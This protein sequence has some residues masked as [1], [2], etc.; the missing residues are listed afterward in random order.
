MQGKRTVH[1]QATTEGSK[2]TPLSST[3]L[4]Q[5]KILN[6]KEVEILWGL[7]NRE[8]LPEKGV[9][10]FFDKIFF[11]KASLSMQELERGL[12]LLDEVKINNVK[13]AED[14]QNKLLQKIPSVQKESQEAENQ[15]ALLQTRI[16]EQELTIRNMQEEI[17][18]LN[19]VQ[20]ECVA[21]RQEIKQLTATMPQQIQSEVEKTSEPI[22]SEISTL[23][24]EIKDLKIELEQ[25]KTEKEK[26]ARAAILAQEE[27]QRERAKT[28]EKVE[29]ARKAAAQSTAVA[30]Q[31]SRQSRPISPRQQPAPKTQQPSA[32]IE[33]TEAIAEQT[34]PL[35]KEVEEEINAIVLRQIQDRGLEGSIVSEQQ[36]PS[37]T[38]QGLPKIVYIKKPISK[39]WAAIPET[40]NR[41]LVQQLP[42]LIQKI[43]ER[44]TTNYCGYY[45]AY[46]LWCL[47]NNGNDLLNRELFARKF[48][49]MLAQV[50]VLRGAHFA[51]DAEFIRS[52]GGH[53]PGKYE[54][55]Q[56]IIGMGTL[57]KESEISYLLTNIFGIEK[58]EYVV[59]SLQHGTIL[60][61]SSNS[62][63]KNFQ[64]NKSNSLFVLL[65][66]SKHW[67][68]LKV[69]R[70]ATDFSPD[71]KIILKAGTTLFTITDSLNNRDWTSPEIMENYLIPLY[72]YITNSKEFTT[73]AV[74]WTELKNKKFP[75]NNVRAFFANYYLNQSKLDAKKG[76]LA[77][78]RLAELG[79]VNE[80][81]A[82]SI[83]ETVLGKME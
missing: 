27:V 78:Q 17:N 73:E 40:Q 69:H 21:L 63:L 29:A 7:L 56:E 14:L 24:I 20:Q 67:I 57:E 22:K 53:I 15:I 65:N 12:R 33:K 52:L 44:D 72:Q 4:L 70:L 66:L 48:H 61:D 42:A 11:S 23:E 58:N 64:Q 38:P 83:V 32:T 6:E 28:R 3:F 55:L 39:N 13:L 35:T 74:A 18:A 37:T 59:L 10:S 82:T 54:E 77:M 76:D 19:K 25:A 8:G 16:T 31:K 50:S 30:L 43:S 62:A 36:L 9:E 5:K 79:K 26:S 49:A 71:N 47:K 60:G 41:I 34:I 2:T 45:A 68:A 1:R 80:Q 81:L 46:N 75:E 51:F